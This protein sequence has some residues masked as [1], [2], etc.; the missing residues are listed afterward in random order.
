MTQLGVRIMIQHVVNITGVPRD[1]AIGQKCFEVF[2]SDICQT[3]CALKKTIDSNTEQVN[4]SVNIL[5]IEGKRIPISISTSVLRDDRGEI[6]GGVETFRDLSTIEMLRKEI[7]GRYSFEDIISKSHE[8]QRIFDILPDIAVSD[9]KS[10]RY[11]GF[12]IE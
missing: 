1:Q 8:F 7:Q 12:R 10:L 2:R 11:N 3:A 9:R 4:L 6:V 5:T